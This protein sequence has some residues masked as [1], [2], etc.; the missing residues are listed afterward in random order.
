LLRDENGRSGRFIALSR[1]ILFT[2]KQKSF[3]SLLLRQWNFDLEKDKMLSNGGKLNRRCLVVIWE[4]S[5][6]EERSQG[7]CRKAGGFK[8]GSLFVL[9]AF[10]LALVNGREGTLCHGGE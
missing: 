5:W 2:S 1:S 8:D 3:F 10:P 4:L 7:N 6:R 9:M